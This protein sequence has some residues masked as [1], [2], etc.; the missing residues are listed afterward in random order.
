MEPLKLILIEHLKTDRLTGMAGSG[1]LIFS[2]AAVDADA[3]KKI[4]YNNRGWETI[5]NINPHF[6][7]G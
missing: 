5:L 2:L 1:V 7:V 3:I 4:L 6:C